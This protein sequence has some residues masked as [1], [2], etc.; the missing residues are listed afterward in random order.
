ME[1]LFDAAELA[2]R[3]RGGVAAV[4]NFDGFHV[5]HQAVVGRALERARREARP[6]LVVT[7]DPHPMRLFRPQTPPFALTTT[8][9]KL[10]LFEAF[11]VDAGVV[12]TFDADFARISAEAFV[13]DVLATRLGVRGV[14]TGE[15]FTFGRGALG[16]TARLAEL[17]A[18]RGI[19]AETVAPVKDAGG[20]IVSSTRVR[21]ALQAGHCDE[22][23]R[24]L[25]RPFRIRGV[26]EHGDKRGRTIGVPTANV[27]LGAYLRPAYGI[28][29]V[30]CRLAD[31]SVADGVASLG[32][33][34]MFDPPK[35]LL[36]VWLL[37]FSG[38]LYG[39][40]IET[41][42]VKYLR[43]ELKL[44]DLDTLKAQIAEDAKA[45]RAALG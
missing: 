28:Y 31:G 29:A 33:R 32:I 15:D 13:D 45:A 21:A 16:T 38:D 17:G 30:R 1:R 25:G 35:E 22:A 2:D 11:G 6:A 12:L 44:A 43:P 36:E 37:G 24:L 19:V 4:G 10:E 20:A 42:F 7:F 8:A 34:P 27:T 9:Q 18:A 40:E 23:A 41:E 39:Q 5:G 14:V 3:L 26:V